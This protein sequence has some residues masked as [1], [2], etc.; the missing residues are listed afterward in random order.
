MQY[1]LDEFEFHSLK[2]NKETA[3]KL[4]KDKLQALCTKICD[5][6]PVEWWGNPPIVQ[7]WGCILTKDEDH[8]FE[9][10]Y[11]DKCP[12]TEICPYEHKNWSK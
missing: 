12:V 7:P 6:M 1:I 5:E 10:K 8:P 3:I 2:H 11:C 4:A 9:E